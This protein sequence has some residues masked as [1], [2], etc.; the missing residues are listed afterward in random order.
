MSE[1]L[2]LRIKDKENLLHEETG[3]LYE[4]P[5]NTEVYK[6]KTKSVKAHKELPESK[7]VFCIHC[8]N[9]VREPTQIICEKCGLPVKK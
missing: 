4:K 8:G 6:K 9:M 2:L 3:L 1:D 7:D 5:K